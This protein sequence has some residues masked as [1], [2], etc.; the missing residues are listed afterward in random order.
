MLF[1]GF[2]TFQSRNAQLLIFSASILINLTHFPRWLRKSARS[3]LYK[4]NKTQKI[5][6]G[7]GLWAGDVSVIQSG[8]RY[9]GYAWEVKSQI[10][11]HLSH[12]KTKHYIT[13]WKVMCFCV[14][15]FKKRSHWIAQDIFSFLLWTSDTLPVQSS[16]FAPEMISL[17]RK[18][19]TIF[20]EP[21][22]IAAN[23]LTS[24]DIEHQNIKCTPHQIVKW[25]RVFRLTSPIWLNSSASSTSKTFLAVWTRQG[26]AYLASM[27]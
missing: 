14:I 18:A 27:Q 16:C 22:V 10:D 6:A 15:E 23:H 3:L 17:L 24:P 7:W 2:S 11:S 12:R 1:C 13:R 20:Q 9:I 25:L 26:C 4:L 5:W 8:R 21:V 19:K